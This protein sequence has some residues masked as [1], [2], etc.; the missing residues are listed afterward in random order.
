MKK[1]SI[2]L[3]TIVFMI[4]FNVVNA[5]SI[6]SIDMDIF[7]DE[8]GD[9]HITEVWDCFAVEDSEWYHTYNNLNRSEI[10]NFSVI[11][12][13][14]IVYEFVSDWNIIGSFQDKKYKCGLNYTSKG[15]ELCFG[16][17]EY[18]A[19]KKYTA[20]YTITNFVTNLNDSQMIYWT[21]VDFS[22]KIGKVYIK[23]YSD[24]KY[25]SSVGVWGYGNYGGIAHINDGYIEMQS[26][27][28]L[29]E[30]EYM[31]VLVKFPKNTFENVGTNENKEFKYYLKLAD[32][33]SKKYVIDR[34]NEKKALCFM[35]FCMVVLFGITLIPPHN[36][37]SAKDVIKSKLYK[38]YYREIPCDGDLFKILIIANEYNIIEG[39]DN[40]IGAI[41]LLWLKDKKIFIE[42]RESISFKLSR[43]A[44][45]D[46]KLEE[47]FYYM[48]AKASKDGILEKKEFEKWID[49]NYNELFRWFHDIE[50][51]VGQKLINEGILE[52]EENIYGEKTYKL[53][54]NEK[55]YEEAIKIKGLKNYLRDYT[56]IHE[57]KTIEITLF[58]DYLVIAQMLGMAKEVIK[59]FKDIYPQ[60]LEESSF[61]T[62][63]I[64]YFVQKV[65]FDSSDVARKSYRRDHP[66]SSGGGFSSGG[67]GGG[68]SGGGRRRFSL[69]D[70]KIYM[71]I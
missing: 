7:I 48:L 67:G 60:L 68:S 22:Q 55:F 44:S 36:M 33:G 20:Q 62:D 54:D 18:N 32:K 64:I 5:N 28:D 15:T 23:I 51:Y 2:I 17:S 57:R 31:T 50:C 63:N 43:N 24:F 3:F 58:E 29:E 49:K 34:S 66:N 38:N 69:K 59:E 11:D 37:V 10:K 1:F 35:L 19:R 39:K 14:G 30:N 25:D 42:N 70:L 13:D 12:E 41:L 47:D 6:S 27:G 21:L 71:F 46:N 4:S 40:L 45:F 65:S 56:L 53:L 16:I 26:P 61:R 8:S 9:A 52:T